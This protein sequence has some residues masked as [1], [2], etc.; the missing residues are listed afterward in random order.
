MQNQMRAR[1]RPAHRCIAGFLLALY[2]GCLLAQGLESADNRLVGERPNAAGKPT[3]VTVGVLFLDI[4]EINSVQQQFNVDMFFRITWQDERLS[5]PTDQRAGQARI[6]PLEQVW[7]P[8]G[9]IIND[10]GLDMQLPLVVDVDDL[11]NVRYR[12]RVIGMLSFEARLHDFPFDVQQLPVDFVSYAYSPDEIYFSPES[13]VIGDSSSIDA[14]GWNFTVL[15]SDFG[16]FT[17]A[18]E[19]IVRPRLTFF[20]EAER[21]AQYYVLTLFLPMSLIIFMSWM[22]FWLQPDIVPPR[23]A[24]STASIFSLIAFG[25]SIRLSL[26]RISYMTVADVFVIGCTMMV[27]LALSVAVMGSRMA[28]AGRMDQAL[29]LNAI[30]RWAYVGLFLL[31][32]A[33]VVTEAS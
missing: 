9:L 12:Q 21:D 24:I 1:V 14:E 17:I 4:A 30:A 6:V 18:E 13:G 20:I 31:V 8:K 29:R 23:I 22:V 33:L 10:R 7:T 3:P 27:F 28:S 11:G 15:E 5:L 16:E 26:P 32:I 2:S 25:F 19:G